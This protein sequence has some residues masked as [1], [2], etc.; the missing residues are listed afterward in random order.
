MSCSVLKYHLRGDFVVTSQ[1]EAFWQ[2][3]SGKRSQIAD[4]ED[5]ARRCEQAHL[6]AWFEF[7]TMGHPEA[8]QAD[9][10]GAADS[11]AKAAADLERSQQ[12]LGEARRRLAMFEDYLR[13]CSPA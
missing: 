1:F 8:T 11:L 12:Q 3:V 7:L 5:V 2:F 13:Q 6:E 9:R 4:L 10:E